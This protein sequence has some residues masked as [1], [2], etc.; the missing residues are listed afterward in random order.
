[1]KEQ[2]FTD[3]NDFNVDYTFDSNVDRIN[4][5][6]VEYGKKQNEYKVDQKRLSKLLAGWN[7]FNNEDSNDLQEKIFRGKGKG[8]TFS[9]KGKCAF[10]NNAS[11]RSRKLY[12]RRQE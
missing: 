6:I 11:T 8:K 4:T 9:D 12:R 5:F 2:N 7:D 1:V 10:N 3:E